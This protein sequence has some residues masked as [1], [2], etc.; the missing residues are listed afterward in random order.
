MKVIENL[1]KRSGIYELTPEVCD[2]L[3]GGGV[4]NRPA[5]KATVRKY[6]LAM[7]RD[8]WRVTGE[9]ILLDPDGKLLDGQ[10]RCLASIESGKS[11]RAVVLYGHWPFKALGV[12]RPRSAADVLGIDKVANYVVTA[13]AARTCIIHNKCMQREVSA[14]GNMFNPE[15]VPSNEEIS[16]WVSKNQEICDVV[17]KAATLGGKAP[18]IP[19]SATVSAWYL[20]RKVEDAGFV[21]G[22]FGGLI[23]GEALYKGDIRVVLRRHYEAKRRETRTSFKSGHVFADLCKAWAMRDRKDV[24]LF[25]RLDAEPFEFIR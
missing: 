18:L 11:F 7:K 25:R 1:D 3:V 9:P 4:K 14:I 6:A 13:S 16:S 24:K 12:G 5:G 17:T 19:I 15:F 20:A 21:D 8:K 23:S 22:W 2:S 10:H